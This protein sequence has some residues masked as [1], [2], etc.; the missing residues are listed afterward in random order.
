M[1]R[2]RKYSVTN[3]LT[4]FFLPSEQIGPGA[5]VQ[6]IHHKSKVKEINV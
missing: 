3:I 6:Q 4:F 1:K 2:K 5:A